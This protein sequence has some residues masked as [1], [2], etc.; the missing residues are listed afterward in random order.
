MLMQLIRK[1]HMKITHQHKLL[2]QLHLPLHKLTLHHHHPL[3]H[4]LKRR[5]LQHQHQRLL[6]QQL[7]R[8]SLTQFQL[9]LKS[10]SV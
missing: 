6:A 7:T 2:Q 5:Q 10:V 1:L 8:M 4:L 9:S 3:L